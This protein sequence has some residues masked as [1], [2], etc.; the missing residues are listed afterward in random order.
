MSKPVT[1]TLTEGMTV[2]LREGQPD[3]PLAL[4]AAATRQT[5]AK[6]AYGSWLGFPL[7]RPYFP[8]AVVTIAAEE[9]VATPA[10][11]AILAGLEDANLIGRNREVVLLAGYAPGTIGVTVE[12]AEA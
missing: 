5:A 10:R 8:R 6:A 7:D 11:L 3:D 12:G 9:P 2:D 1:F 4:L